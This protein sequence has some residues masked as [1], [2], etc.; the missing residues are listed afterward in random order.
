MLDKIIAALI[1]VVIGLIVVRPVRQI[2]SAYMSML[3]LT[4]LKIIS[5]FARPVAQDISKQIVDLYLKNTE[6]WTPF[7]YEYM[8]S[9]FPNLQIPQPTQITTFSQASQIAAE[10]LAKGLLQKIL[11]YIAPNGPITPDTAVDNATRF[12]ATNLQFQMS[13]W[14]LHWVGDLFS[15]GMMKSLKD[16]PNAISWSF[17]LGWLSWLVM[18]TPFRKAI[19]DP[20][21]IKYNEVYQTNILSEAQAVEYLFRSG[22]AKTEWNE[23]MKKYGYNPTEALKKLIVSY[24]YLT[25]SELEKAYRLGIID[26]DTYKASLEHMGYHPTHLN[27]QM[28]L[29]EN[30]KIL[31]IIDNIAREAIQ[32]FEDG[33]I[34]EQE[35]INIL[36]ECKWT[37][38][39][40]QYQFILSRIK[41]FRNNALS[42]SE[43]RTLV[44]RG[45]I[46]EEEYRK[47]LKD[48][49]YNDRI[50]DQ[51][52]LLTKRT[53]DTNQ[54]LTAYVKGLITK[55]NALNKLKDLGYSAQD[56]EIL[57]QFRTLPLSIEDIVIL[58]KAGKI[59]QQEATAF[60]KRK[61][62]PAELVDKVIW[63]FSPDLSLS[64]LYQLYVSG[65]ITEREFKDRV[66]KYGITPELYDDFI[67]TKGKQLTIWTLRDAYY[68]KL[69]RFSEIKLYLQRMGYEEREIEILEQT[70]FP[71]FEVWDIDPNTGQWIKTGITWH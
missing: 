62:I 51:K 26:K 53:L 71:P 60:L 70:V 37:D 36:K 1:G 35:F 32:A 13:A 5:Q 9:L 23:T 67:K 40:I 49:G 50:I 42:E 20:L 25:Q 45:I 4:L 61:G 15:L 27:I 18:G 57:L 14:I 21:E 10:N 31:N 16:L 6:L 24:K 38:W 64:N 12:F 68:A 11:E 47:I 44:S 52:L 56:A 46:S 59:T 43:L 48:R 55:E 8:R 33:L 66:L 41:Q 3:W 29:T 7:V 63:L 28:K 17:G 19:S 34:S 2:F 69:M 54:I 65:T 58:L 22:K 30:E 39:S